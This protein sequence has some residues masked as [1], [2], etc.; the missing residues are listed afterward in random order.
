LFEAPLL[1]GTGKRAFVP[2]DDADDA[3]DPRR[4]PTT[5]DDR[6][7]PPPPWPPWPHAAMIRR[8]PARRRQAM[9]VIPRRCPTDWAPSYFDS[10]RSAPRP[11]ASSSPAGEADR[12][13]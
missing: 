3:D 11:T 8:T 4:P 1:E 5:A 7:R 6:R 10:H 9:A 2:P 13:L 12:W